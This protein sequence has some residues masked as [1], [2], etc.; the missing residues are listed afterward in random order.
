MDTRLHQFS[1]LKK[2]SGFQL[3]DDFIYIELEE[4]TT[5]SL[6]LKALKTILYWHISVSIRPMRPK[7]IFGSENFSTNVTRVVTRRFMKILDMSSEMF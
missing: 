2:K 6:V 5:A 4:R 3:L 1:V 7:L